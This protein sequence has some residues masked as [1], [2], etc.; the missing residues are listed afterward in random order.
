M[1][2]NLQNKAYGMENAN[3]IDFVGKKEDFM[4]R[5][6]FKDMKHSDFFDRM[7]KGAS[8]MTGSGFM[9]M[10]QTGNGKEKNA[11]DK[12]GML[13]GTGMNKSGML[14]G[15]FGVKKG[16]NDPMTKINMLG[17][18]A[19][20]KKNKDIV[21]NNDKFNLMGGF[22][23]FN[24]PAFSQNKVSVML[25]NNFISQDKK[26]KNFL[27]KQKVSAFANKIDMYT[28]PSGG[29]GNDKMAMML[30]PGLGG[31]NKI[32]NILG[33]G[34]G[35]GQDKINNIL[36]GLHGGN[37]QFKMAQMLQK[38]RIM[39]DGYSKNGFWESALGAADELSGRS[40]SDSEDT[41]SDIPEP[42]RP[43]DF[44]ETP[45]EAPADE[46][47]YGSFEKYGAPTFEEAAADVGKKAKKIGEEAGEAFAEGA[48]TAWGYAKTT[49]SKFGEFVKEKAGQAGEFIKE[50]VEDVNQQREEKYR[51]AKYE[52]EGGAFGAFKR[53][54]EQSYQNARSDEERNKALNNLGILF[55]EEQRRKREEEKT[56]NSGTDKKSADS[57][58]DDKKTGTFKERVQSLKMLQDI[59]EK[60]ASQ[61]A[62]NKLLKPLVQG[63]Q[64]MRLGFG[65]AVPGGFEYNYNKFR[66]LSRVGSSQP[67]GVYGALSDV[68][69]MPYGGKIASLVGVG[70][71]QYGIP[72]G[73]GMAG[74]GVPVAQKGGP[75]WEKAMMLTGKRVQ[76][77]VPAG[78]GAQQVRSPMPLGAL[79]AHSP[80]PAMGPISTGMPSRE[81]IEAGTVPQGLQVSPY[82]GRVVTY[83]RGKYKKGS[84]Q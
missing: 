44:E 46:I 17:F 37:S 10:L 59:E 27:N 72:Y 28:K 53:A 73:A 79:Q 19:M 77:G 31:G 49:G 30:G 16:K 69:A 65:V 14:M 39:S 45:S 9:T 43:S 12:I 58:T 32:G 78:F 71:A 52:K 81:G 40:K 68:N 8:K 47:D 41:S 18:G 23:G 25:P 50:K 24:K 6:Y 3:K 38:P 75:D 82:S 26:S 5:I 74:M 61:R 29:F 66:A 84:R 83:V 21:K 34:G 55:N 7:P 70:R 76:T 13:S 20:D 60:L 33:N 2:D 54:T 48:G 22:G 35:F 42:P 15:G 63:T 67:T 56:K 80:A 57:K 51:K 1:L 36:G 11:A 4:N 62:T 64:D